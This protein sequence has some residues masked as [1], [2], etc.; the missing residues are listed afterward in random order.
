V[1]V[2]QHLGLNPQAELS[3]VGL[4]KAS[5]QDRSSRF[6][7]R[8]RVVQLL[9]NSAAASQCPT[10]GLRMA[11]SRQLSDMGAIS[12]LLSHQ[13][14]LRHA[15]QV[16]CKYRHLLNPALAHPCRGCGRHRHYPRG[17]W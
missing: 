13:P 9:E 14:N 4:S 1:E 17:K 6:R 7:C 2:V 15:L 16:M 10:L 11:E 3:K 12:L 8:R 5:L